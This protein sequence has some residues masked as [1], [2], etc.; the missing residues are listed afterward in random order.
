MGKMEQIMFNRLDIEIGKI[1]HSVIVGNEDVKENIK[2]HR[3]LSEKL[4]RAKELYI[5]GEIS[6]DMY[7]EKK[8]QIEKDMS[9]LQIKEAKIPDLPKNWKEVYTSLDPE[10]KQIFWKKVIDRVIIT[11]ENKDAPDIFFRC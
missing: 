4:R 11:N 7:L 10:H 8:M 3:K 6:K 1:K 9:T 5:E 2:R